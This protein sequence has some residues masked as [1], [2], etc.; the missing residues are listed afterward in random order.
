MFDNSKKTVN[1]SF[2]TSRL[3]LPDRPDK[4]EECSNENSTET[5]IKHDAL[6][7]KYMQTS[8]HH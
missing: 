6:E 4:A 2:Q 1:G 8:Q 7:F 5:S 3:C